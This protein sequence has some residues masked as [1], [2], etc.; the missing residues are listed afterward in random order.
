MYSY[1][2]LPEG[3]K[4]VLFFKLLIFREAWP[5]STLRRTGLQFW[6][7]A[8]QLLIVFLLDEI[9]GWDPMGNISLEYPYIYT[10]W[11]F[12]IAMENHHF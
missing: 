12:N 5:V 8:L 10:L 4:Q 3:N 2:S 7:K 9:M 11:L 1:V 6:P